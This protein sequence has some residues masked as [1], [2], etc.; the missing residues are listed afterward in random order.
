MIGRNAEALGIAQNAADI[1]R[2]ADHWLANAD[3]LEA[4]QSAARAF[5]ND[6]DT[7]LDQLAKRVMDAA[8][9]N[10]A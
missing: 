4:A 1:A 3:A 5:A 9:I 6:Q 2:Y 8:R 7:R 10:H